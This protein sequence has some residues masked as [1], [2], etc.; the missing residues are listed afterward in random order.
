MLAEFLKSL[1]TVESIEGLAP[2]VDLSGVK[3]S[4]ISLIKVG[5]LTVGGNARTPRAASDATPPST[6]ILLASSTGD[7]Q[8]VR[9][10]NEQSNQ[11][12]N[13]QVVLSDVLPYRLLPHYTF[14][15]EATRSTPVDISLADRVRFYFPK[16]VQ[17]PRVEL[18]FFAGTPF[19]AALEVDQTHNSGFADDGIKHYPFRIG[20]SFRVRRYRWKLAK[21]RLD[22]PIPVPTRLGELFTIASGSFMFAVHLV[23]MH[24]IRP[25]EHHIIAFMR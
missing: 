1:I 10:S 9:L 14:G 19:S 7:T 16:R 15:S 12:A 23:I 3:I 22:V 17:P 4:D 21:L 11:T 2:H 20:R 25:T 24:D 5:H 8:A 18:R 6:E 13:T